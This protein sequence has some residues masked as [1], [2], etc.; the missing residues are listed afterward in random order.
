MAGVCPVQCQWPLAI[1]RKPVKGED[2]A[3]RQLSQWQRLCHRGWASQVYRT[4]PHRQCPPKGS[5][6]ALMRGGLRVRHAA[7]KPKMLGIRRARSAM[8]GA[9][10]LTWCDRG[11]T[12]V[13][14]RKDQICA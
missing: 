8:G 2:V 7:V 13:W 14:I 5:M 6:N 4:A 9:G 12:V 1:P 11:V 3:L 10:W